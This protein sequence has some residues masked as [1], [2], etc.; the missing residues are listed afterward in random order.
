MQ[1]TE[2]STMK[3]DHNLHQAGS[4]V[5]GEKVPFVEPRLTFIEPKLVKR[6]DIADVTA[7]FFGKF[8]P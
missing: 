2:K 7:G 3:P 4:A 6:G 8:S 5:N 1:P